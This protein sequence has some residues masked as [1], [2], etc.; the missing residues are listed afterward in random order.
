MIK[1]VTFP[2]WFRFDAITI[3]PFIFIRKG[4]ENDTALIAHEKA[5][6]DDQLYGFVLP[7]WIAYLLSKSFRFNAEVIGHA[8]EIRAGGCSIQWAA[9]HIAN[10]Y[11]TG[12]TFAQAEAALKTELSK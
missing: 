11:K 4:R 1:S 12:C 10:A 7:W 6:L 8:A 3:W 5:H 2:K 9:A